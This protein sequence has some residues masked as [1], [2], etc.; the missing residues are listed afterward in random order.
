MPICALVFELN[1]QDIQDS[2]R[3]LV[4]E[5]DFLPDTPDWESIQTRVYLRV[6]FLIRS[7][8]WNKSKSAVHAPTT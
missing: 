6:V 4:D 8:L 7:L 2:S 5:A 1:E 3:W